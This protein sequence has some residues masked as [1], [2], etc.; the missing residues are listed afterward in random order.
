MSESEDLAKAISK[1]MAQ[2]QEGP[3]FKITLTED[4]LKAVVMQNM[5]KA[6]HKAKVQDHYQKLFVF[7]T[8]LI[9]LLLFIF[10]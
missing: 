10:L 4:Q 7:A 1:Y 2:Q 9:G 6:E 5:M 3:E 8:G